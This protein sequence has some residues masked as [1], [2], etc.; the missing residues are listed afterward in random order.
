MLYS[1]SN[2]L[3]ICEKKRGPGRQNGTE[4]HDE[5]CSRF[6]RSRKGSVKGLCLNCSFCWGRRKTEEAG[7]RG[8]ALRVSEI[9]GGGSF[10]PQYHW[11]EISAVFQAVI[12]I[13][14]D[15][16][17]LSMKSFIRY[18]H[19]L[20]NVLV[21]LRIICHISSPKYHPRPANGNVAIRR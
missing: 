9:R 11:W 4:G 21:T 17:V 2:N 3:D 15:I 18:Y 19:S 12:D 10:T 5:R 6:L 7:G 8:C 1:Q 13:H 20:R 16:Q 14:D